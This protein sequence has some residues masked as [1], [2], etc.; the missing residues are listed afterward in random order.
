ESSPTSPHSENHYKVIPLD[1]SEYEVMEESERHA[2][3]IQREDTSPLNQYTA[4]FG[5]W[6]S[7]FDA[8]VERLEQIIRNAGNP[9]REDDKVP[10]VKRS[11]EHKV[12]E[13]Y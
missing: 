13:Q 11:M 12:G 3:E 6:S 7:P 10:P 5:A 8:E 2:K 4:D 9:D 1:S